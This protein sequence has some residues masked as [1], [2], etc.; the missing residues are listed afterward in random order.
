MRLGQQLEVLEDG[1]DAA[2]Q[3]GDLVLRERRDVAAGDQDLALGRLELADQ[4][5]DQRGLAAA[6][7]ADQ[8]D[9]LAA[10]DAQADPL[11][12][13]VAARVDLGRAAQLD[14]RGLR[15]ALGQVLGAALRALAAA[16]KRG[17][18]MSGHDW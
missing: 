11:Q 18:L 8:E 7:R 6:G 16:E 13:D 4:H 5:L 12:G 9:E 3:V 1:A 15:P 2:A 17:C 10:V 14:D